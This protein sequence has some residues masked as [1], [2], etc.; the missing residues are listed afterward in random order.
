[1]SYGYIDDPRGG[2]FGLTNYIEPKYFLPCLHIFPIRYDI[3]D[4]V[5]E[6][7]EIF[8]LF[9]ANSAACANSMRKLIEEVLTDK[10]IKRYNRVSGRLK[11]LNLHDRILLFK[12]K[13][14]KY[15]DI[16]DKLLAVKWI[17]NSGSHE[18]EV[19]EDRILD[20]LEILEY[21]LVELYGES[22]HERIKNLTKDVN[23]KK[24]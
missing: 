19:D 13:Y 21:A 1:M 22:D 18:L 20:A 6:L 4:W 10:K 3:S 23:K 5:V 12:N 15:S 2:G 8:S 9:W 7:E 16:S 24:K 14:P 17:G 11:P